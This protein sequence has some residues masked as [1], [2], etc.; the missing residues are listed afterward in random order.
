MAPVYFY[1]PLLNEHLLKEISLGKM[2]SIQF[3]DL[4]KK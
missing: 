4:G 3:V 1:I 2:K